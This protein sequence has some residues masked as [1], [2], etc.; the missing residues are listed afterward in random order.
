MPHPG[1]RPLKYKTPEELQTAIDAYFD[2]CNKRMLKHWDKKAGKEVDFF[3]PEPYTM[4]GLAYHLGMSR[5]ALINYKRKD[6]FLP[7]IK[8][9]RR[10]VEMD[11]ERRLM[12]G[13]AV[14]GA[15]FNL[16]NNFGWKDRSEVEETHH[17]PEPIYGGKSVK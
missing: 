13:Q 10:K 7:T 12:E 5:R 14:A 6:E 9:A 11:V 15:I 8:Q 1:G 4:S 3:H 16:K 2:Y 17:F